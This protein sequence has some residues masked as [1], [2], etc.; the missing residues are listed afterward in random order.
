MP[1]VSGTAEDVKARVVEYYVA[2][3]A[4]YLENWSKESLGFHVGIADETTASL[5]ESLDN[6]NAFLAER[7]GVVRGTRVLDA[8]C[9]VGGSSIWLARERGARVTGITIVE[10]QVQLAWGFA[11][12]HGVADIVDF[13]C[14]DMLETSFPES[15][16]DV[17]WSLGSMSHV[18]DVQSYLEHVFYL[19]RDGGS[20]VVIDECVGPWPDRENEALLCRGWALAPLRTPEQVVQA[21]GDVG[22]AR[23]E[24][25]DLGP[26]V[27]RS[28]QAMQAMASRSLFKM[29]AESAFAGASVSAVYEAHVR[30]ALAFA[31]GMTSGAVSLMHFRAYRPPRL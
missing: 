21:L 17:V 29:R 11:R 2:T 20:F 9:G 26:R 31:E 24:A 27:G 13:A 19:L 8:G 14:E 25:I 3:E 6:T 5:A 12:Q 7:A 10:R 23:A 18:V 22:F 15:S 1:P 30:G 16:F 28:V 4:S